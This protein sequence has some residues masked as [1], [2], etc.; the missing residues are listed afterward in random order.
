M[1]CGWAMQSLL[2]TN[3]YFFAGYAIALRSNFVGPI[4]AVMQQMIDYLL[5]RAGHYSQKVMLWNFMDEYLFDIPLVEYLY[6]REYRPRLH[7]RL[8]D[9]PDDRMAIKMTGFNIDQLC[10]LYGHFGLR[11]LSILISRQIC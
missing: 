2:A 10:R 5:A 1:N 11:H 6:R 4:P 7:L 9:L 3:S 8:G